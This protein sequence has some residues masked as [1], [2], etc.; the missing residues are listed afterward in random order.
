MKTQSFNNNCLWLLP[1]LAFCYFVHV[2]YGTLSSSS[3]SYPTRWPRVEEEEGC[4]V[5]LLADALRRRCDVLQRGFGG[6]TTKNVRHF[7]PDIVNEDLLGEAVAVVVFLGANDD[8]VKEVNPRQ[9][10]PIEEYKVSVVT[11]L[12]YSYIYQ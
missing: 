10:V 12:Y 4:W 3:P 8:N 6:Y 11:I 9:H 5:S 2:N 1:L 7:L